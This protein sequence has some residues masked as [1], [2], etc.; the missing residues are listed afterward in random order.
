MY[1]PK[2][3]E[4]TRRD[5]LHAFMR[6]H[7]FA[8]GVTAQSGLFATH[9]PLLLDAD[10]GP[11]GTLRGHL[12]RANPQWQDLGA[13]QEAMVVF[14]GPHAYISPSS[15]QTKLSVPTWNYTAVHAYGRP[16]LIHD[17]AGIHRILEDTV[18][19][20]ESSR[21]SPW[22]MDV[23]PTDFVGK[24]QEQIVGFE[25]EIQ[26]LEGKFKLSQNRPAADQMGVIDDLESSGHSL[27]KAVAQLM[28]QNLP[29]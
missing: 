12:A 20:Y 3:F 24:L 27:D 29:C 2:A 7:S 26:R 14:Q 15:Y 8:M 16:R 25:L 11:H 1:I 13:D 21:T 19:F 28:K 5:V 6:E 23:L 4:E 22:R 10:R 9:I 18:A 17:A